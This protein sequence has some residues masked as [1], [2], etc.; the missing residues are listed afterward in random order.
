[1]E[2][3]G[4]IAYEAYYLDGKRELSV[5]TLW[6]SLAIRSQYAWTVAAEAAVKSFMQRILNE[7]TIPAQLE[8]TKKRMN[9]VKSR[10]PKH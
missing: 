6:D 10:I 8:A 2:A 4:K 3:I 9:G 5:F 7:V 1:M